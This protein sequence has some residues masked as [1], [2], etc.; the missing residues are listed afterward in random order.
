[1]KHRKKLLTALGIVAAL[2]AGGY[3]AT[4]FAHGKGDDGRGRHGGGFERME[5]HRS[6]GMHGG[7]MF[8]MMERYDSNGDGALSRDEVLGARADQ[9]KKFDANK[10]GVLDLTEYRQ[11]WMEAM[12]E[13][14]VK[15][16]QRQDNDGDGKMTT[17]EFNKKFTRMMTWM[18]RNH[19]DKIDADDM[20]RKSHRDD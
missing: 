6:G 14:M 15:S 1:M 7:G 18:D 10:D 11:L 20:H 9:F 3:A 16:F 17:A 19:D 13:R 8:A 12:N 4:S 5:G 2:G